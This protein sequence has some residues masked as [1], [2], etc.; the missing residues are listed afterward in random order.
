MAIT[1]SFTNGFE[2]TDWTEELLI[3]P[4]QWGLINQLGLFSEE[5]VAEHTVT[6]EKVTQDAGLVVDRVRGDRSTVQK[7][8]FKREVH[9]VAVP[10]FPLDDYISPSD[11]QGKRAYGSANAEDTTAAVRARKMETIR[12]AHSWTLELARAKALMDGSVY[13]PNGTVSMNWYTEFG[14]T[15][16]AQDFTFG[17]GTAD[18]IAN[19]EAVLSYIQDNLGNGQQ[20][21]GVIALCSPE[22][23]GKLIQHPS[24]KTAYQYYQST[25]EPLRNRLGGN[26]TVYRKFEHGGIL[27][28]EY[29]AQYAGQ[30]LITA[31]EARFL[32]LGT[33]SFKTFYSPANKFD[34]VNTL[35]EQAYFF[36]YASP[37]GDK[38]EIETESNFVNV[39]RRPQAVVRAFSS[40]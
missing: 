21:T 25:Q 22:F 29:R 5:S 2:V 13:A 40:N 10:H 32:P 38:I 34:F 23:F 36:E 16:Q 20:M 6:F 37:K 3:V 17:T 11:V 30:R 1:R 33:D 12:Q 28:I 39:V 4:N 27:Y 14:L 7:E 24:I 26:N 18:M 35:G 8:H 9:A 19:G 15:Q 31:G